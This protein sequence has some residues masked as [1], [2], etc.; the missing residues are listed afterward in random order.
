M[1][2]SKKLYFSSNNIND[3]NL[4][5]NTP[6]YTHKKNLKNLDSSTNYL[7]AYTTNNNY[8]SQNK[9]DIYTLIN[10]KKFPS[11]N[12]KTDDN[13]TENIIKKYLGDEKDIE[14]AKMLNEKE[15]LNTIS[16]IQFDDKIN[17][18][19]L[20]SQNSYQ[21]IFENFL[22]SRDNIKDEI[23][24]KHN[25]ENENINL[26]K[27][28]ITN[29]DF[30]NEKINDIRKPEIINSKKNIDITKTSK[31]KF[32][33]SSNKF[34]QQKKKY[35]TNSG[36]KLI[37][38]NKKSEKKE[39]K[40]F[41]KGQSIKAEEPLDI[42]TNK[43]N[44]SQVDLKQTI[45]KKNRHSH[46]SHPGILTDIL[47]KI[48]LIEN[49]EDKVLTMRDNTNE[50]KKSLDKINQKHKLKQNKNDLIKS[51]TT[52]NSMNNHHNNEFTKII[53]NNTKEYKYHKSNKKPNEVFKKIENNLNNLKLNSKRFSE[54]K[55]LNFFRTFQNSFL[56]KISDL[57]SL[58]NSNSCIE[59][60]FN[61]SSNLETKRTNGFKEENNKNIQHNKEN[62][63]DSKNKDLGVIEENIK[64]QSIDF[65]IPDV[66]KK[67]EVSKKLGN[68]F[69][70]ENKIYK[71]KEVKNNNNSNKKPKNDKKNN[72]DRRINNLKNEINNRLRE[73]NGITINYDSLKEKEKI[74]NDNKNLLD[75]HFSKHQNLTTENSNKYNISISKSKDNNFFEKNLNTNFN[76]VFENNIRQ[77]E[78]KFANFKSKIKVQNHCNA[79]KPEISN[80]NLESTDDNNFVDIDDKITLDEAYFLRKIKDKN[81]SDNQKLS[82]KV[83]KTNSL[84]K[85]P[86]HMEK[87]L[88]INKT[89]LVKNKN[90]KDQIRDYSIKQLNTDIS[91]FEADQFTTE[92]NYNKL[93]NLETLEDLNINIL[94][95]EIPRS[96]KMHLQ[97]DSINKK[98]DKNKK[99]FFDVNFKND[100]TLENIE[101][102]CK[103]F[104]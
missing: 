57:N 20:I 82:I 38:N 54:R 4:L 23:N 34:T 94:K 102:S 91:Y 15:N 87:H 104:F 35:D 86:K 32:D 56:N 55:N 10:E 96:N 21:E 43:K 13:E 81:T 30:T 68:R 19:N 50:G 3:Y 44:F 60:S 76:Q 49:M 14:L 62:Q 24:A 26:N 11:S 27:N 28:I 66:S 52:K 65:T 8:S 84:N 48:N 18:L 63:K 2:S 39:F 92:I 16:H 90:A 71:P 58:S 75:N 40:N 89:Y 37:N 9:C 101:D 33:N 42:L 77:L 93:E 67:I 31:N 6:K 70:T 59:K 53:N 1:S 69:N 46:T 73:I 47:A 97:Q 45:H 51:Y 64:N 72:F 74:V 7:P 78:K 36:K 95:T 98:I 5:S 41:H 99:S 25:I 12:N 88:K 79:E 103:N 83:Q 80:L 61:I 22:I 100:V 29:L 17:N 85:S